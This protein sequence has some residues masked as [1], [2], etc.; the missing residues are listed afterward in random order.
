[1]EINTF[2]QNKELTSI[3]R[4]FCG[5]RVVV[6]TRNSGVRISLFPPLDARFIQTSFFAVTSPVT[7]WGQ[8]QFS[9]RQETYFS[10]SHID[11]SAFAGWQSCSSWHYCQVNTG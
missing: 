7:K 6:Q 4:V 1:M 10:N 11:E 5:H 8:N 3:R 2:E 9:K